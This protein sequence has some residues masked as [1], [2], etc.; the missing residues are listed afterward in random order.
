MKTRLLELLAEAASAVEKGTAP[1]NALRLARDLREA[2]AELRK[3]VRLELWTLAI[4]D[5]R[6]TRA[7]VYLSEDDAMRG[8]F[9]A[10]S[11]F[12]TEAQELWELHKAGKFPELET[13]E[14][15][16]ADRENTYRVEKHVVDIPAEVLFGG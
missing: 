15:R 14:A 4:D 13:A 1:K 10:M 8:R 11:E 9:G 3:G 16:I 7:R 2:A 12:S 5:D 6:S